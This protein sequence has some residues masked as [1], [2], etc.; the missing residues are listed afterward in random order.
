ME[1]HY[2]KLY[3]MMGGNKSNDAVLPRKKDLISEMYYC[4][5]LLFFNF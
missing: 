3:Y 4:S 1:A 2:S 5:S